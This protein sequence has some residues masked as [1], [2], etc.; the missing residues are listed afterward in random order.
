M[1]KAANKLI[2]AVRL[3]FHIQ[4]ALLSIAIFFLACCASKSIYADSR[5]IVYAAPL[6]PPWISKTE[7][8]YE[9]V[10]FEILSTAAA[11]SNTNLIVR[12]VPILRMQS[13]LITG[14]ADFSLIPMT[15]PSRRFGSVPQVYVYKEPIYSSKIGIFGRADNK[16]LNNFALEDISN[17]KLGSLEIPD[18]VKKNSFL[19]NYVIDNTNWED[20]QNNTSIA[21]ALK[22]GRIDIAFVSRL[23]FIKDASNLGIVNDFRELK[24]IDFPSGTHI[25][26]SKHSVDEQASLDFMRALRELSC[27]GTADEIYQK[28]VTK[29]FPEGTA[30]PDI[31]KSIRGALVSNCPEGGEG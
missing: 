15:N 23:T 18:E 8:G 22:V 30:N 7:K 12:P 19:S 13:Y 1:P 20:F 26:W 10:S 21:K 17:Y 31:E 3:N 5:D 2:L 27:N 14:E 9:G 16:K 6:F 29:A 28:W 24:N 11:K 4:P 25:V